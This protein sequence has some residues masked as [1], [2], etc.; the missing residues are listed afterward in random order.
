MRGKV[1]ERED[2]EI[3]IE[4]RRGERGPPPPE[5]ARAGRHQEKE[6]VQA[7]PPPGA[8]TGRASPPRADSLPRGPWAT[9]GGG[10]EGRGGQVLARGS[11]GERR[12]RRF[13][14]EKIYTYLMSERDIR[15]L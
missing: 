12:W 8:T 14:G 4:I 7:T 13:S 9:W 15:R 3:F 5:T 10:R 11:G 2:Q 1:A 6:G